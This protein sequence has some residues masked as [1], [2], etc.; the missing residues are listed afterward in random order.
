VIFGHLAPQS[1]IDRIR[2]VVEMQGIKLKVARPIA[3]S[4]Q[5]EILDFVG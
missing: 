4:R 3:G 1:T 2:K 5:A